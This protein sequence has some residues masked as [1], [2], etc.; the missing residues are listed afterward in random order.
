MVDKDQHLVIDINL[1]DTKNQ[2]RFNQL[3]FQQA[4]IK[5]IRIG[6]QTASQLRIVLDLKQAVQHKAFGLTPAGQYKYHRLVIDLTSTGKPLSAKTSSKTTTAKK[7]RNLVVIIDAGHGGKDPGAVSRHGYREKRVVLSI[8]R[9]SRTDLN[10]IPGITAKLTRSDDRFLSLRQRL[11]K[12]RTEKA[13][14]FLSIHADAAP[15]RSASG[16]SVYALSQRGA[17][18]ESARWLADRENK[19]LALGG[20]ITLYDK[21]PLLSSVLLDMSQTATINASLELGQ[22]LLQSIGNISKLHSKRVGQAAFVV[23]KS[24]DIPSVLIETGFIS[25]AKEARL[26]A[27]KSYQQKMA[28]AITRGIV[29]YFRAKNAT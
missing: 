4:L 18:S 16:A 1:K 27:S 20:D 8:A 26:L 3:D 13:D 10:K 7:L 22:F 9:Y 23:L 19:A 2:A 29:A 11:G 14:M 5:N 15:S 21:N 25:N 17:S 6:R 12:A 24:P 28:Q